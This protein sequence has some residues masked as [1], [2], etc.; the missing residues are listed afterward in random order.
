MDGLFFSVIIP[1]FNR[2]QELRELLDSLCE[3]AYRDFEVII[4]EDGSTLPANSVIAEF[5]HKLQLTYF[6]I[7]NRGQGFARNFGFSQAKGDYF[8]VFDSDCLVPPDYFQKVTGALRIH[9]WD[10]FGGPDRAHESFSVTQKAISYAMTSVLTTGGIRGKKNHLGTFHPRSFNMGISRKV[11][12]ETGGF[13]WTRRSEDLEFSIRMIREGFKVG[14]IPDAWVYH[15]R[16]VNFRQF[17]TQIHA[18]GQGRI[19]V[20]RSF[21]GELKLIHFL[22]SIFVLGTV[23]LTL[24]NIFWLSFGYFPLSNWILAVDLV[25]L[26]WLLLLFIDSWRTS[27]HP[28]VAILGV[29][30]VFYQ[31]YAYGLGFLQAWITGKQPD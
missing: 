6:A 2:P 1:V 4:V 17:F 21:P 27:L 10:A 19:K 15:K 24:L 14:L 23:F 28:Y 12:E 22:P 25:F 29:V 30:A 16:R 9:S 5:E 8:I 26:G 11:W 7:P 31:F 18:F 13:R 20:A 3:Q